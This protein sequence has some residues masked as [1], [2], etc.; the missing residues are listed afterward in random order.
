M[1]ASI[2]GISSI[3]LIVLLALI[4]IF[5]AER[6]RKFIFNWFWF[7]HSLYPLVYLS[8]FLHGLGRVIQQPEFY[9]YISVP[10]VLFKLDRL[11]SVKRKKRE[12]SVIR[13]AHY[14][15]EVTMLEL[16]KPV[17]F[18]FKSGQWLRIACTALNPKEFH[19][20][21]IASAPHEENIH[22]FIRAVGPFTSNIRKIYQPENDQAFPKVFID[23]P[24]G[25]THQDWF[26]YPCS[27]LVGGGIGVTPFASILK[28]IAYRSA[29]N[30]HIAC[31]KVNAKQSH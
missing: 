7:T 1:F 6:S 5:A 25:E 21:T 26:R 16:K 13:T 19:P 3:F 18:D 11:T 29:T 31:K 10:L 23:G 4:F 30:R 22:L 15:S 9:K 17:D 27:V 24:Y 8:I 12:I 14:P 20:F 2:T 28:D